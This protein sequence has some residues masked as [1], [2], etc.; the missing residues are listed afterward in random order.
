MEYLKQIKG[1]TNLTSKMDYIL[2]KIK[3]NPKAIMILSS[4]DEKLTWPQITNKTFKF[5]KSENISREILKKHAP[6]LTENEAKEI[7]KITQNLSLSELIERCKEAKAY[8]KEHYTG[9]DKSNME[10]P[11]FAIY[12]RLFKQ[13]N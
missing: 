12:M 13:A 10:C 7:L 11:P 4:N 2:L 6:H 9:T 1:K 5:S 8:W 3:E